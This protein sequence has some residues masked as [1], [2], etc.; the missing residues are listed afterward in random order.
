[1]RM[2]SRDI[3]FKV[4]HVQVNDNFQDAKKFVI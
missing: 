4:Q 2:L 1:M 3:D